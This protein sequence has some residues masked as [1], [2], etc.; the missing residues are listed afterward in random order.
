[1]HT[2]PDVLALI[3]LGEDAGTYVE[4]DHVTTCP[5]CSKEVSELARI[6]DVGR[7]ATSAD[8]LVAPAPEVWERISAELGLS[9]PTSRAASSPA[10]TV[11]QPAAHAWQAAPP[12]G[13]TPQTPTG[14]SS[15]SDLSARRGS[16]PTPP[17][18]TSAAR[19]FAALAV[20]AGLA[21]VV[22]IGVGISYEQRVVKPVTRVIASAQLKA[23]PKWAGTTGRAEVTADGR[24]NRQLVLHVAPAK[25]V[26][27]TLHVW[28]MQGSVRDPQ[29]MGVVRDGVARIAIPPG[30][31][32]FKYPVV[33]VS[34]EPPGDQ[35]KQ[36]S[37]D[38]V[39]RGQL[40]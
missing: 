26:D 36:H 4:T 14:V 32:L 10:P 25:P 5:S 22:G 13:G 1:M 6:A 3:A 38:S 15:V 31:S 9:L 35:D 37:G 28:L 21:L 17:R 27:G 23:M 7:S 34:D 30:M 19:R 40:V 18:Q 24:G 16:S 2:S 39:V 33:D 12:S 20:A 8:T 29:N 11:R